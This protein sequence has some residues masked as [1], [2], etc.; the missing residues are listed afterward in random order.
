[1]STS[2]FFEGTQHRPF[3]RWE[4]YR[5]M[6]AKPFC[7]LS[8]NPILSS[9]L[10]LNDITL[11]GFCHLEVSFNGCSQPLKASSLPNLVAGAYLKVWKRKV[12][13]AKTATEK[14]ARRGT[15]WCLRHC[16]FGTLVYVFLAVASSRQ[17]PY[18]H[19]WCYWLCAALMAYRLCSAIV[20]V[21]FLEWSCASSK[22]KNDAPW[23]KAI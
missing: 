7:T 13:S 4:S 20:L 5:E 18:L 22:S 19:M 9:R 3:G 12:C 8:A 14:L 16:M 1:M 11:V 10:Q 6:N 21:M 2:C 17:W 15:G 23:G